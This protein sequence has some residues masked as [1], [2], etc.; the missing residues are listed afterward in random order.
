MHG[1]PVN[2]RPLEPF[3]S[4]PSFPSL[5]PLPLPSLPSLPSFPCLP[6]FPSFPS[7]PFQPLEEGSS[8][9]L[10]SGQ[11]NL[12]FWSWE[13]MYQHK[14]P[15]LPALIMFPFTFGLFSLQTAHCSCSTFVAFCTRASTGLSRLFCPSPWCS[16]HLSCAMFLVSTLP[17]DLRPGPSSWSKDIWMAFCSC[18][19]QWQTSMSHSCLSPCPKTTSEEPL[20]WSIS[21]YTGRYSR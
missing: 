10:R 15:R 20:A 11:H 19:L 1:M 4:L 3:P 9:F 7:L 17:G 18:H 16:P 6:S 2:C 13:D 14:Q 12:F 8:P 21:R 5:A